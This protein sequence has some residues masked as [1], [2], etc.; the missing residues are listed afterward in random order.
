MM[1]GNEMS[2]IQHNSHGTL[3]KLLYL[4]KILVPQNLLLSVIEIDSM[5]LT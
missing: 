5:L 4:S 2:Q 3:G 1:F